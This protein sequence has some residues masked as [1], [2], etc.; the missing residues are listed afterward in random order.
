MLQKTTQQIN[1]DNDERRRN[2]YRKIMQEEAQDAIKAQ[3]DK[4]KIQDAIKAQK[5]EYIKA[6]EKKQQ[7]QIQGP[8]QK[9]KEFMRKLVF[10]EEDF[11]KLRQK[12]LEQAQYPSKEYFELFEEQRNEDRRNSKANVQLQ[13]QLDNQAK[14]ERE[15]RNYEQISMDRLNAARKSQ[16]PGLAPPK[17]EELGLAQYQQQATV[18]PQQESTSNSTTSTS[19]STSTSNRTTSTS[20]SNSTTSTSTSN[21]T[22]TIL[23]K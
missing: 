4:I 11:E 20:T 3:Q 7:G 22:T 19:T 10:G 2:I 8:K 1:D 23:F 12:Q 21:R 5:D 18:Q 9:A 6:Q 14:A 15:A 17:E 13:E 16:A